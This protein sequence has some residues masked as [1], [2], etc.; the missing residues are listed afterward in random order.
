MSECP[1][2]GAPDQMPIN[3]RT[4]PHYAEWACLSRQRGDVPIQS[5]QCE[6]NLMEIEC[7][8]LKAINAE[9]LAA[10]NQANYL[11]SRVAI[12]SQHIVLLAEIRAAIAKAESEVS[13]E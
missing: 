6:F 10:L 4:K 12:P 8:I 9:L 3:R 11:L 5:M 13:D 7:D 1:W 2:C